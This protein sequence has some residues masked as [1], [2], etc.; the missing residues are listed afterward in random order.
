MTSTPKWTSWVASSDSW[1]TFSA[2]LHSMTKE[3]ANP[4]RERHRLFQHLKLLGDN[5]SEQVRKSR[6]VPTGPRQARHMPDAIGRA[7]CREHDGDRP[8]RLS[9]CLN[10]SRG[11]SKDDV[12]TQMDQLGRQFGQLVDVFRPSPLNDKRERQPGARAAS[13]LSTSQ[14]AWRQ[15]Q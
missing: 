9:G 11:I 6:D 13:P 15:H 1:L 12:H 14:V 4:A 10:F 5:I 7:T 2:H 8:G 3:N